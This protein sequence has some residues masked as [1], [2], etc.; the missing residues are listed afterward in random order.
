MKGKKLSD[1]VY[2]LPSV[3]EPL[4]SDVFVVVAAIV[5][6]RVKILRKNAKK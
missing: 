4:S 2:Y 6:K 5:I 3:E 1:I